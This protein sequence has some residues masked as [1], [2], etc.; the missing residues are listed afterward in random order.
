MYLNT[1]E[2]AFFFVNIQKQNEQ[3]ELIV[4]LLQAKIDNYV[5]LNMNLNKKSRDRFL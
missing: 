4:L 5:C 2:N 3:K 1:W